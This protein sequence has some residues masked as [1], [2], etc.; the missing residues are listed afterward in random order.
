MVAKNDNRGKDCPEGKGES[1]VECIICKSPMKRGA[2]ICLECKSYQNSIN[3]FFS[4]I[5]IK[6]LVALIPII[7][8]AFVFLKDQIVVHKSD[9]RLAILD[10]LKDKVKVAITNI[11]DRPAIL[12]MNASVQLVVDGQID[13]NAIDLKKDQHSEISSLIKPNETII[14]D[15]IPVTGSGRVEIYTCPTSSKKCG[16]RFTFK[17]IPFDDQPYDIETIYAVRDKK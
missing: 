2:K 8:L 16:Y 13:P 17:V 10:C 1:L 5:D 12:G 15:Y 6:S 7:T 3:R 4:G 11:G 14:M 9:L